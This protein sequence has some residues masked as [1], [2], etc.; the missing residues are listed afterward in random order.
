MSPKSSLAVGCSLLALTVMTGCGGQAQVVV[1]APAPTVVETPDPP[2]AVAVAQPVVEH[3]VVAAPACPLQCLSTASGW[4]DSDTDQGLTDALGATFQG[5]RSCMLQ[6]GMNPE[7]SSPMVTLRFAATGR[8]SAIGVDPAGFES[9]EPC[10]SNTVA[11][12]SGLQM[13][14]PGRA[15]IRCSEQ[16][17]R[18]GR[19]HSRAGGA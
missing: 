15:V 2:R 18:P 7:R 19:R 8:L 12:A 17:V 10:L 13:S 11:G 14:M 16:C 6:A 5:M 3:Q 1:Q 9:A 4:V